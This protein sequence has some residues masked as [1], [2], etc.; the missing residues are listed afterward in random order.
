MAEY[1]G[2]LTDSEQADLLIEQAR[3]FVEW[4]D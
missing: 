3:E 2:D 1:T 4:M